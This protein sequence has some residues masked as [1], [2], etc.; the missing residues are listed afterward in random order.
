[1][2]LLG[3]AT[4]LHLLLTRGELGV[5]PDSVAYLTTAQTIVRDQRIAS[6]L[7]TP[8]PRLIGEGSPSRPGKVEGEW[9]VPLYP[10]THWPPGYPLTIAAVMKL[11]DSTPLRSAHVVALLTFWAVLLV[12]A[13]LSRSISGSERGL[14]AAALLG[15]LPFFQ[16]IGRVVW[17]EPLFMF[18]GLLCI[19]SLGRWRNGN[20]K[21]WLWILS[22]TVFAALSTYVRYVGL[23]FYFFILMVIAIDW[24]ERDPLRRKQ[25]I[26]STL[27]SAV[28]YPLLV[29][30]LALR[31]FAV[32]G[33]A[34]GVGLEPSWVG[35]FGSLR[36]TIASL[37]GGFI[38][39][40]RLTPGPADFFRTFPVSLAVWTVAAGIGVLILRR[41]RGFGPATLQSWIAARAGSHVSVLL[42]GF[43]VM[44]VALIVLAAGLWNVSAGQRMLYPAHV[45][46]G[47]LATNG[48]IRLTRRYPAKL[49]GFV[50]LPLAATATFASLGFSDRFVPW[51][52]LNH[53]RVLESPLIEWTSSK[54]KSAPDFPPMRVEPASLWALHYVT[55]VVA[56]RPADLDRL[57][58][59]KDLD[60]E[61]RRYRGLS[62]VF[63]TGEESQPPQYACSAYRKRYLDM[64][65]R[66]S[67]SLRSGTHLTAWWITASSN[68]TDSL[69]ADVASIEGRRVCSQ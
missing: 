6:P 28:M 58:D 48:V 38:P 52:R 9:G 22:S 42:G 62:V 2:F 27:V 8:V 17:S 63:V 53:P 65:S 23:A 43:A 34:G 37:V 45:C 20:H 7:R 67:D 10:L 60:Q 49:V 35:V 16:D 30:P 13:A 44:F 24:W 15:V 11:S 40:V 31:N 29:T 64:L 19:A 47:I 5:S 36:G 12:V 33:F 68:L 39:F 25:L 18:F 41:F 59:L 3:P 51:Q 14:L 57:P 56:G 1:V 54:V 46:L 21:K 69:A 61:L 32:A 55:S 26:R 66:Y 50:L 4:L